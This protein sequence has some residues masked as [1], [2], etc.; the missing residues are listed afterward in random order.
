MIIMVSFITPIVLVILLRPVRDL[1][2]LRT[3][4]RLESKLLSLGKIPVKN[5][6]FGAFVCLGKGSVAPRATNISFL[7]PR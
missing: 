7:D 6:F 4:K 3:L 5:F 2:V 1:N